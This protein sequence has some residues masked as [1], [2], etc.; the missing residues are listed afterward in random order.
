MQFEEIITELESLSNPEDVEGMARF[1][2]KHT[3]T[4]GVRMPELR[5]I[6]KTAGKDHELAEKLWNAG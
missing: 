4:Y 3:L 1:G 5:R 6:A 2:I